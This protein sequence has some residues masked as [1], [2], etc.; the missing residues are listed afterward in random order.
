MASGGVSSPGDVLE[1]IAA[2]AS[3]VQVGTFL[4]R[5]PGMAAE[6]ADGIRELLREGNG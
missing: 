1:L 2:G 3:M 4:L 5:R 6:L